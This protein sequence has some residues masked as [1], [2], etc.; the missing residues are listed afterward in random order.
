MTL[1]AVGRVRYHL[2]VFIPK[3]DSAAPSVRL[4]YGTVAVM[5]FDSEN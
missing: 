2:E 4:S 3:V 1:S 5:W